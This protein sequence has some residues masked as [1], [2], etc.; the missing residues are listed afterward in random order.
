MGQ[1]EYLHIRDCGVHNDSLSS[2]WL[3]GSFDHVVDRGGKLP[4]LWCEEFGDRGEP[5]ITDLE[6]NDI[7][8]LPKTTTIT[9][10]KEKVKHTDLRSH[11]VSN[12][13]TIQSDKFSPKFK[14]H[15]VSHQDYSLQR[16]SVRIG[17]FEFKLIASTAE[18]LRFKDWISGA[19]RLLHVGMESVSRDL[20]NVVN[21]EPR[22]SC[23]VSLMHVWGDEKEYPDEGLL[24]ATEMLCA[25][26]PGDAI[27]DSP[28]GKRNS[29]VP[30]GVAYRSARFYYYANRRRFGCVMANSRGPVSKGEPGHNWRDD[31]FPTTFGTEML[32]VAGLAMIEDHIANRCTEHLVEVASLS[33]A[34]QQ[35]VESLRDM[36]RSILLVRSALGN[37]QVSPRHGVQLWYEWVVD[38]LRLEESIDHLNRGI[39]RLLDVRVAELQ[40]E[41]NQQQSKL[42][43][44][45]VFV[46]GA[47][48]YTTFLEGLNS[49]VDL[50]RGWRIVATSE[51]LEVYVPMV[52][53]GL[54]AV[55]VTKIIQFLVR[56]SRIV[57]AFVGALL[58]RMRKSHD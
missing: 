49:S 39:S 41:E 27:F 36:N 42:L 26:L 50:D 19:S 29:G 10:S 56:K 45:G 28:M 46:A 43:I 25:G 3:I 48:A 9:G 16:E 34:K 57:P 18:S 2:L 17:Y 6:K 38:G 33:T 32:G 22:Q 54:L 31:V 4:E 44:G 15:S 14:L 24:D 11:R 47:L 21:V 53:V 5:Q 37:G 55:V 51:A 40:A 12:D 8:S 52:G 58:V 13:Y 35:D 23:V 1:R 30:T 20:W 7:L